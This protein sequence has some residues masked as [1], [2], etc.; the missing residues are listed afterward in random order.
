MKPT[1]HRYARRRAAGLIVPLVLGLLAAWLHPHF[2]ALERDTWDQRFARRGAVP[3]S[4]GTVVLVEIDEKTASYAPWAN[5]PMV[6]WGPHFAAALRHLKAAGARVVGI[7]CFPR[8]STQA[9]AE[10]L[11]QP[12]PWDQEYAQAL[13]EFGNYVFVA[14]RDGSSWVKPADQLL[15]ANAPRSEIDNLGVANFREGRAGDTDATVRAFKP[16]W[17]VAVDGSEPILMPSF[18]V[19]LAERYLG[20]P[21][22]VVGPREIR[23][24]D[25]RLRLHRDGTLLINYVG[26][27]RTLPRF[28]FCDIAEGRLPPDF[29]FQDKI[30]LIGE[31]YA[32]MQDLHLT[33]FSRGA[34]ADQQ[35]TPGVEVWGNAVA[36][37]LDRPCLSATEVSTGRALL[38]VLALVT[39]ALF[40]G[41]HWAVGAVVCLLAML[42]WDAAGHWLFR[43]Q[44]YLLLTAVPVR[45]IGG[46][47]ALIMLY[48]YLTEEREKR[49]IKRLWGRYLN[50]A[51][52][53]HVLQHPE[54]Q[55]LGGKRAAVTVLFSVIRGCT[56]LSERLAPGEVV[57]LLNEYLSAM[58]AV[59]VAHGGIVDKYVGDAIMALWGVPK[60]VPDGPERAVRTALEMIARLETLNARWQAESRPALKIGVGI[61]TGIAVFG[62]IG[63]EHKMDLTVIGDTVNVASRL[64]GMTKEFQVPILITEATRQALP[65]GRFAIRA[66]PAAAVRGRDEAVSLY[67][68]DGL[69]ED[70]REN[71]CERE[72]SGG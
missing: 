9:L 16:L 17:E 7:D 23:L 58:S 60:P 50:P 15:F 59:V 48:R 54:D 53:E 68:V 40:L 27:T 28:S 6:M 10:K 49:Q 19:R 37:I 24:G 33:P 18:A 39:G 22:Q 4:A 35:H 29:S 71:A 45:L 43:T 63:S 56:S 46:N 55:G 42:A 5:E 25:R 13:A 64:E 31:S 47:Y 65:E 51:M 38:L 67:A 36:T 32:G 26:P 20:Q 52:V 41:V 72:C 66:L 8:I 14:I 12:L 34:P 1:R 61:N 69:A 62:H 30:V 11:G 21:A 57:Q 2:D 44:H 3:A 70:R